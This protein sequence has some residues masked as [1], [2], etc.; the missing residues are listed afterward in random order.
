MVLEPGIAVGNEPGY[1]PVVTIDDIPPQPPLSQY[2]TLAAPSTVSHPYSHYAEVVTIDDYAQPHRIGDEH[3]YAGAG[4]ES[5]YAPVMQLDVIPW[6][7][8]L[9]SLQDQVWFH[10]EIDRNESERRLL[11]AGAEP[12]MYLV[13]TRNSTNQSYVLTFA[14]S[15]KIVHRLIE[16]TSTLNSWSVDGKYVIDAA[17]VEEAIHMVLSD[18]KT[19]ESI[20]QLIPVAMNHNKMTGEQQQQQEHQQDWRV[21]AS[22]SEVVP[23]QNELELDFGFGEA[24]SYVHGAI[25]RTVGECYVL[26]DSQ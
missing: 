4:Q 18:L 17:S 10:G 8:A 15:T 3:L 5:S 24:S 25:D 26:I 22:A 20:G 21:P 14:K 7:G 23:P 13:S 6:T 11:A 16:A 12:G 19:Q 9:G 1:A 2:E